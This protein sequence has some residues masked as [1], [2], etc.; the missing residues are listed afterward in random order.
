MGTKSGE[1]KLFPEWEEGGGGGGGNKNKIFKNK[2][3][4]PGVHFP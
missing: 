1:Y 2:K 3:Y 4:T